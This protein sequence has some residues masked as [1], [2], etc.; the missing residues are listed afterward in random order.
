MPD[1]RI[2]VPVTQAYFAVQDSLDPLLDGLEF[3]NTRTPVPP[4]GGRD[5]LFE[6]PHGII[7]D[8]LDEWMQEQ[9]VFAFMRAHG[10]RS[11]SCDL[12]P[13]CQTYENRATANGA[14][15]S[16][17]TS[18]VMQPDEL[19]AYA[20]CKMQRF[21]L[22]FSGVFK[23]EILNYFPTGVYDF[24]CDPAFISDFVSE[25][26]AEL[27]L[28]LGHARVSAA[29]LGLPFEE[30]LAALPMNRVSEVHFS[31]AGIK[32]GFWEDLHEEPLD[33]DFAYLEG[34]C[35]LADVKHVVVE[36]YSNPDRLVGVVEK[37]RTMF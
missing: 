33:E 11:F 25:L 10:I 6:S 9:D 30:Y 26:N 17:P 1:L 31:R 24:V 19:I 5:F 4:R 21:R 13:A 2:C 14:V 35:E 7:S 28:D 8:D 16:F 36:Y 23:F 20:Q 3:K 29:N 15:R 34:V 32:N 18:P 37:L 27:L 12:G 22:E